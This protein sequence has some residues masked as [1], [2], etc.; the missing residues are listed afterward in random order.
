MPSPSKII[1]DPVFG[2]IKVPRGLM[3]DIVSHPFMQ[4]LTRIRQLGLASMVYPAAQH[5]RFQHS[6]GAFHLMDEA[7]TTLSQKGVFIF[8]VEAEAVKAAILMHDMGHAPFSHVLENVL[9][10]GVSH[11]EVSLA[12]MEAMN[13]ELGGALGLAI[14]VFRGDYPKRFLHQLM[15]SQLDVDRLDYLVRDCFFTGVAEGNIGCARIIKMLDVLDDELVVD[16]KG[17]Y[18]VENY[19]MSRYLMYWQVY[20]HK[21]AIAA[22]RVLVSALG[23]AR[24]LMR[25]GVGVFASPSLAYFLGNDVDAG[26]FRSDGEALWHYSRLDDSDIWC[27]LKAWMDSGDPILR[28]L[29][30]DIVNRHLFKVEVSDEPFDAAHVGRV[31]ERIAKSLGLSDEEVDYF[32]SLE[33]ASNDIYDADRD[34][35]AVLGSDGEAMDISRASRLLGVVSRASRTAKYF[36]CYQ[37]V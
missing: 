14:K 3:L 18:P 10:S 35:I 16:P 8:D 30:G 4:R 28:T 13:R 22:Q 26:R 1:N 2:F 24:F 17:V 31:R 11:E 5:T 37:R 25:N 33:E 36:L 9:T 20:L 12:M 29:A 27:A 34:S 15:S 23:R 6:I 7:I 21:T 32:V 19:L